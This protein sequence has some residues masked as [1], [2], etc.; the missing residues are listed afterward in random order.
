MRAARLPRGH[1]ARSRGRGRWVREVPRLQPLQLFLVQLVGATPGQL[2]TVMVRGHFAVVRRMAGRPVLWRHRRTGIGHRRRR[3]RRGSHWRRRCRWPRA[4][5]RQ[6]R[7]SRVRARRAHGIATGRILRPNGRRQRERGDHRYT[8]QKMMFHVYDPLSRSSV[9]HGRHDRTITM[10]A[11]WSKSSP[12]CFRWYSQR[13]L[14]V[15][16][17]HRVPGPLGTGSPRA[18]A[19]AGGRRH[20]PCSEIE[21]AEPYFAVPLNFAAQSV[22]ND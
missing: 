22:V 13:F 11:V 10:A 3:H 1:H 19:R 12:L 17:D 8:G 16:R 14:G 9:G 21:T 5:R 7:S 6:S 2:L 20:R 18:R 15:L 4:V